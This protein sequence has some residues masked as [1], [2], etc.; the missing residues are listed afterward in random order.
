MP[1]STRLPQR[2]QTETCCLPL[3]GLLQAPGPLPQRMLLPVLC[4]LLKLV[5]WMLLKLVLRL[6]PKMAQSLPLRC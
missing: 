5:L 3:L 1:R 6:L 4:L 2:M